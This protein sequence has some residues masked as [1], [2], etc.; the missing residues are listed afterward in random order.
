MADYTM[1]R[2]DT[3]P[4]VTATLQTNGSNYNLTGATVK[5]IMR[6][7]GA[8]APKV[9]A[10]A[11]VTNAANGA[12]EYAWIAADTDTEGDFNAEFEVTTSG[13]D[14]ITFPNGHDGTDYFTVEIV[15]DLG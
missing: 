14:V 3:L 6:A 8:G 9:D 4:K 15:T 1:K 13:G 12:V 10:A 11:T 7:T 2:N 5:F